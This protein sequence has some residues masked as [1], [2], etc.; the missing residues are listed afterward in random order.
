MT[1]RFIFHLAG[2]LG[3]FGLALCWLSA[4][5][6]VAQPP[7]DIARLVKE[8]SVTFVYYDHDRAPRKHPGYTTFQFDVS[9]RSSYQYTWLDQNGGRQLSIEPKIGRLAYRLVNEIQLP[10]S[11]HNDEGR[12]SNSL[13]KHEF[14]HVAITLDPRVRMLIDYLCTGTPD[15]SLDLLV[16][17]QVTNEFIDRLI[18]EAVEPRYESVLKLLLANE[19][20]L[21]EVTRHGLQKLP[22]RRKYFEFLFTEPNLKQHGFPYLE[23]V[24]PLLQSKAY[25]E[26]ELPYRLKN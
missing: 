7:H 22:N 15:I 21:D 11:L 6:A 8:G 4:D 3:L 24:K 16:R 1:S 23:E 5:T 2:I 17:A 10:K 12:W 9:Y 13:L 26:V 18:H 19:K 25:R 20:D 14:D